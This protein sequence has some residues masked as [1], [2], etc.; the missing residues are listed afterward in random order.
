MPRAN[1]PHMAH[2]VVALLEHLSIATEPTVDF[3]EQF[4]FWAAKMRD[5]DPNPLADGTFIRCAKDVLQSVGVCEESF[6]HYNGTPIAGNVTQE[7]PP[8]IPTPTAIANAN[9]HTHSAALF[10]DTF[11]PPAGAAQALC[12]ALQTAQRPVAISLPVFADPLTP[13]NDNWQTLV[14]WQYGRVLDPPPGAVVIAGHAICITGFAPDP[15]EPMGGYFVLRN[16]WSGAWGAGN[17]SPNSKGPEQ[18]YGWISASYIEN[19]LWEMCQL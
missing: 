8:G 19:H 3:S 12:S 1:D 7:Q 17:P 14:G 15:A 6:W 11:N 4:L 10:N 16:S 13:K 2:A 18:G 5:T 9:T